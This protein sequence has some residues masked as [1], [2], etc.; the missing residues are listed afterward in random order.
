MDPTCCHHSS[1][2]LSQDDV[3]WLRFVRFVMFSSPPSFSSFSFFSSSLALLQFLSLSQVRMASASD[4]PKRDYE[5]FELGDFVLQHGITLRK[6]FLAYKTYGTLNQA[7]SNVIVYPT[8]YSG[9]KEREKEKERRKKGREREEK[10]R[11]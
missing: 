8:W 5:I 4:H 9:L 6:A 2:R 10:E 3:F 11:K 7:K 1:K